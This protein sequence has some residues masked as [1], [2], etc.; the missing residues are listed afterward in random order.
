VRARA[1]ARVRPSARASARASASASARASARARARLLRPLAHA[2][3]Q[4]PQRCAVSG[5]RLVRPA[6]EQLRRAA[7]AHLTSAYPEAMSQPFSRA[8]RRGST[9]PSY[10][11]NWASRRTPVPGCSGGSSARRA[12]WVKRGVL[13]TSPASASVDA[14]RAGATLASNWPASAAECDA[15]RARPATRVTALCGNVAGTPIVPCTKYLYR[16]IRI[17]DGLSAERGA[18]PRSELTLP[19]GAAQIGPTGTA[20]HA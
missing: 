11:L 12:S 5:G 8:R 19:S 3:R 18:Q 6:Q 14:F 15:L 20:P 4:R 17:S 1:R 2:A 16:T 7:A 9:Q 10:T 13:H